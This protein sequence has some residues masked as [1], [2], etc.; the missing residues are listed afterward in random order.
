[1]VPSVHS[2]RDSVSI[3]YV[4]TSHLQCALE[5]G[6][7]SK[8]ARRSFS[9][10]LSIGSHR[11]LLRFDSFIINMGSHDFIPYEDRSEWEYHDCHQHYHSH[12]QFTSYE[13]LYLNGSQATE[14]HKASFCLEDTECL[15]GSEKYSCSGGRP[16]GVSAGCGDKYG[17]H[18]DCQWLDITDVPTFTEYDLKITANPSRNPAELDYGNN[19]VTCRVYI[20]AGTFVRVQ[21]PP[22]CWLSA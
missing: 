7:L 13:L 2:L 3:Q 8:E 11:K 20:H 14:G 17:A 4:S 6:C 10:G 16:Q 1:M 22:G 18:L 21:T 15:F 12:K 5:E 19:V 9:R